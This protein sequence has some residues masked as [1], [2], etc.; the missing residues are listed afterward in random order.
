MLLGD[1]TL[2]FAGSI[3]IEMV[4]T[5]ELLMDSEPK[6]WQIIRSRRDYDQSELFENEKNKEVRMGDGGRSRNR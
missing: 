1:G 6:R 3:G 4:S 5:D 2:K